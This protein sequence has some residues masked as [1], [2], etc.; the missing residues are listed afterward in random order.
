[1]AFHPNMF[2]A[3]WLIVFPTGK[4]WGRLMMQRHSGH[5]NVSLQDRNDCYERIMSVGVGHL[6]RLRLK[7]SIAMQQAVFWHLSGCLAIIEI[8][9]MRVLS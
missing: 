7:L 4:F 5:S 2:G 6:G 9:T 3:S 8:L 1:M